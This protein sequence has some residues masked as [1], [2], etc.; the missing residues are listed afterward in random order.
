MKDH[1]YFVYITTN[2]QKSVLY[3]GVTNDLSIRIQQHFENKGKPETF[4]GKNHRYKL[5]YFE[6]YSYIEEAIAREKQLKGITRKKKEALIAT[7]NPAWNFL[8]V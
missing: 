4:A 3:I 1:Q 8:V 7:Q 2:P 5:L 6:E